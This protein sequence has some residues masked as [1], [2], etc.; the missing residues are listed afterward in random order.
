MSDL[1][2]LYTGTARN[3]K[4]PEKIPWSEYVVLMGCVQRSFK[5]VKTV[6]ERF[7][8]NDADAHF[9]DSLS[10]QTAIQWFHEIKLLTNY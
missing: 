9:I 2:S 5:D 4:T 1:N 3:L 8:N 7:G 10:G 6:L